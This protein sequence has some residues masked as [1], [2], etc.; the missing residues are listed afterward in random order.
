MCA[1]TPSARPSHA[2]PGLPCTRAPRAAALQA[3]DAAR[4]AKAAKAAAAKGAKAGGGE[5]GGEEEPADDGALKEVPPEAAV[6]ALLAAG[7]VALD[8]GR[9]ASAAK[10]GEA[11]R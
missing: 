11:A 10:Y 9:C 4:R 5:G 1:H 6:W 8:A 7:R 2:S 3:K